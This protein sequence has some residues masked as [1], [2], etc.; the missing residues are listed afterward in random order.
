MRETGTSQEI[1]IGERRS[2]CG[3]VT[4]WRCVL[5]LCSE[6]CVDFQRLDRVSDPK[7][8]LRPYPALKALPTPAATRSTIS[9]SRRSKAKA[10]SSALR[11]SSTVGSR[12]AAC[13]TPPNTIPLRTKIYSSART[14]RTSSQKASTRLVDGSIPC[15]CLARS[16]SERR[17]GGTSSSPVLSLQSELLTVQ[18]PSTLY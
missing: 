18:V 9:L 4:I 15:S 14:L 1:G 11:R 10:T 6:P 7:R 17:P 13:P 5:H 8:S 16:C 12:P 3:L 2:R